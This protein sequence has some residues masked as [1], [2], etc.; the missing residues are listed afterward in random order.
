MAAATGFAALILSACGAPHHTGPVTEEPILNIY[1]W[2]DYI[3]YDTIA[4]FERHKRVEAEIS[5]GFA[6][7]ELV[8]I[9]AQNLAHAL[10]QHILQQQPALAAGRE[11]Q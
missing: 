10:H 2:A 11:A 7:I 5:Q 3:G 4:E 9:Q 6:S 1:N 8:R